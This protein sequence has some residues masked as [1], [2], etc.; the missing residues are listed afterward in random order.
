[1]HLVILTILLSIIHL[2]Y[3]QEPVIVE[4]DRLERDKDGIITAVGNVKVQFKENIIQSEK[5][6][7]DTN[8]KR[9]EIPSKF[10]I[11]TDT[12]EG[13]AEEGWWNIEN[14]EGEARNYQ[15]IL[16]RTF[17]V[18]GEI[19]KRRKDEYD[20]K[21]LDFSSCP[22]DKMDWYLRTK[23]GHAKENERLSLYNTSFRF[24]GIPVIF[25]PYFSYP[26]ADRKTGFL[27]PTIG[28]DTY[29][30]LILKTPFFYVINDYSDITFT[31]DYRNNQGVGL[32]TD[33]RKMLDDREYLNLE[34]DVFKEEK[35]GVWWDKRLH[36]PLTHRWRLK[37]DSNYSPFESWKFYTKVDIPSDRYFFEDF[38]NLSP[39]RYTSFTRS[40]MVGRRDY[41]DYL[42]EINFDYFYDLTKPNNRSTIQR[43]PEVRLYK[44]PVN[45]FSENTY[46]DILSDSNYFYSESGSSG[47]RTDNTFTVYNYSTFGQFLNVAQIMPRITLYLNTK[48]NSTFDSRFLIP[49]RNTFQTNIVK[50]YGAFIHS[51]IPRLSLEY[52]SKVNQ[53]S[54]PY[55]D[56]EDRVDE[57][58]DI[59]LAVYNI[60][61]F[62]SKYYFRWELS[63]GYTFL[64][65]YKIGELQYFSNLKPLKNSVLFNFG[66]Y[67][68][69]SISYYDMDKERLLRT[70]SSFTLSPR[71]WFSYGISYTYDTGITKTKQ[72]SNSI[73]LSSDI[74]K[75]SASFL[76]NLTLGYVQRKTASLLLDRK[77]WNLALNYYED[78]NATTGRRF[79]SFFV[80]L[81]IM[82]YGYRLPF[83][84]N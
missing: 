33:Y 32:S 78:Y 26:L 74:L 55:Y 49:F 79:K 11:K 59:D 53:S 47:V 67:S 63:S 16:N 84:R 4:A 35:K 64:G 44:K 17:Y 34:L 40:Y 21:N 1:M 75:F 72:L 38:Y 69:D 20:F 18:R 22:F 83:I 82:G 68:L 25:S 13:S 24:C 81:N 28:R 70:V 54:L 5:I 65:A 7:Y 48:N 19:L 37:V 66:R 46:L 10:Y 30:T 71:D 42:V 41:G 23:V 3:C 60:L 6:I 45:I 36:L 15:G 8:S 27:Q 50:N 80:I 73:T 31:L 51:F 39:L 57:K 2:S 56:R 62:P 9:I 43:L 29:N 76:N 58:K 12:F 52:I 77:C 61:N 14:D